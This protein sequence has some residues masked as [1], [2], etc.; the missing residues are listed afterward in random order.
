MFKHRVLIFEHIILMLIPLWRS[1][2]ATNLAMPQPLERIAFLTK[3]AS[4]CLLGIVGSIIAKEG[5]MPNVSDFVS[6]AFKVFFF[7][8]F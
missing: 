6:G 7:P 4:V 3:V 2:V 1:N 8:L 5:H